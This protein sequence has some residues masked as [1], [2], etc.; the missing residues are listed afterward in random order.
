MDRFLRDQFLME[1]KHQ[2]NFANIAYDDFVY[3]LSR[4][5]IDRQMDR[6]W[7]SLQS[8]LIASANISKIFWPKNQSPY[9]ERGEFLRTLLKIDDSAPFK[10]RHPR[11]HFEHFDER[12]DDWYLESTHHNIIDTSI[13]NEMHISGK[14]D[15]MRFFNTQK[16]VFRFRGDEYEINPIRN[17]LQEL[18]VKV[19]SEL[20]WPPGF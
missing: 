6:L 17:A 19:N 13:G 1:I 15:Y 18:L 2:C 11:N 12:L 3:V 8:F 9:K 20:K 5:K 14:I 7:Y 4:M 16:F 10:F